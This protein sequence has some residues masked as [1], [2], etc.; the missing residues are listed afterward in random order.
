MGSSGRAR[1][2][3]LGAKPTGLPDQLGRA[4][5]PTGASRSSPRTSPFGRPRWDASARAWP[6]AR[7]AHRIVGSV[8]TMRASSATA[9]ASSGTLKSDRTKT[10]EPS[11]S[12]RSSSVRSVTATSG[13][14]ASRRPDERGE[15]DEAV[16]VAPLVVVPADRLDDVAHHHRGARVERARRRAADDVAGDDRV[17]GVDE[18]AGERAARRAPPGTPRSPR[19]LVTSRETVATRSVTDPSGTGTRIAMPSSLPFRCGSTRPV[20][21]AAPVEVGM[22]FTPPPGRAAG[23]CAAGRGCSGRW[24]RRAR[25]S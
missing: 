15:V 19:R 17:L 14:A 1:E 4:A 18:L 6:H 20:A 9:A 2:R 16:R 23:P 5:H 12:P 10:R 8:A 24:C 21:F 11:T 25:W 7:G 22:M 3:S 13:G